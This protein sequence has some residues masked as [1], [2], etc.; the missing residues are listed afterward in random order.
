MKR[1]GWLVV[2]LA[3]AG[4]VSAAE[5]K[6]AV[7]DVGRVLKQL[8]AA[9][10][11]EAKIDKQVD[12]FKAEQKDMLAEQK[13]LKQAFDEAGEEATSKILADDV[14]EKKK[15]EAKDLYKDLLEQ[16]QRFRELAQ[17]RQQQIADEKLLLHKQ[18]VKELRGIIAEYAEKEGYD[19]ILDNAGLGLNGVNT[20]LYSGA[21]YDVTEAILEKVAA[22]AT[23]RASATADGDAKTEEAAKDGK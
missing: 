22:S 7:V 15:E 8:P 5:L 12:A 21:K 16:E 2:V 17:L 11:A 3:S 23:T 14:R 4:L 6:I 10:E 18:V 13:K 20:V 9:Q 1:I 19:F